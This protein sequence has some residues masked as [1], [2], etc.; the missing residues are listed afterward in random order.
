MINTYRVRC[1]QTY[2]NGYS[3]IDLII[4]KFN[5]WQDEQGQHIGEL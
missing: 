1:N 3:K 4:K 2:N 5:Q